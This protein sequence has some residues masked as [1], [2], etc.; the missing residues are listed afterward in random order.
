MRRPAVSLI[1]DW[2]TWISSSHPGHTAPAGAAP[3]PGRPSGSVIR[4]YG[5]NLLWPDGNLQHAVQTVA[6]DAV[7]L[8]DLVER[9]AM[10]DERR[11]VESPRLHDAHETLHAFLATG[12][13][14]GHD[15]VVAQT[16]RERV[17]RHLQ[18]AR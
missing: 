8:A 14:C 16:R 1:T 2:P 18:L 6:E 7:R 9:E 3:V 17:V 10:R 12:A 11:R 4:D 15:R 5:S 13:Q